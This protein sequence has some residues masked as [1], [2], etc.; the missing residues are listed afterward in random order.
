MTEL[1][2]RAVAKLRSLSSARQ[3]EIASMLLLLAEQDAD[4]YAVSDADM[5][6][7]RQGLAEA[8]AGRFMSEEEVSALFRRF[9]P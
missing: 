3:D 5:A 4:R 1:L 6:R 8:D 2:E 9:R 7:I